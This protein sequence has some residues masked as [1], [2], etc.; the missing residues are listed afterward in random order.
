[1][2]SKI[3]I[4]RIGN[5]FLPLFNFVNVKNKQFFSKAFKSPQALERK[6]E[7]K[8]TKISQNLV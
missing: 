7:L 3:A 6:I 8:L 2:Y 4:F 1:M 5:E